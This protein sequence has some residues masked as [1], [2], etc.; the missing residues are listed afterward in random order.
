MGS[1]F[2]MKDG[3]F[4]ELLPVPLMVLMCCLRAVAIERNLRLLK[5]EQQRLLEEFT[6]RGRDP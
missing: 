1:C 6:L 2:C 4:G 5:D 3:A